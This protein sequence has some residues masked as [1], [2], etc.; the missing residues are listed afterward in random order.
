MVSVMLTPPLY[1]NVLQYGADPTGTTDSTTAIQDAL[2]AAGLVPG[3]AVFFPSGIYLVSASLTFPGNIAIIGTGD[4]IGGTIIRVKSGANLTTPVLASA[5]WYNNS[6]TCGNPIAIKDIKIDANSSTSGTSAHGIVSMNYWSIIERC[7]VTGVT[8]DGLRITANS[9]NGTHITNTCVEAKLI[10]IEARST[11]G[12]GIRVYDTGSPLNSYTDGFMESCIVNNAGTYGI[13]VDMAPGWYLSGNHVYGTGVDGINLAKCYATRVI[14]NYVDGFASG[15]STYVSG[16]HM[17]CIDGRGS[18]CSG[19]IVSFESGSATGPYQGFSIR[20]NGSATSICHVYGNH[21]NGGSQ[22]GSLGYVLQTQPGQ[23]PYPWIVYFRDN[24]AQNCASYSFV[25][26]YVTP[27]QQQNFGHILANGIAQ[28]VTA[29]AGSNAGT[30]PPSPVL[31]RANDL[32]G[33]I[34]FGTGTSPSAGAQVTVTYARSYPNNPTIQL[35][36]INSATAALNLYISTSST[37][38][39]TV[40]CVNAPAASQANT[41][42]GFY[43]KVEG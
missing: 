18:V 10:R 7:F 23:Q 30:S 39:F 43:Y 19:N 2:N 27:G 16:I 21:V 8:G 14:G 40:G 6:T 9:Q 32:N 37:G 1:I 22:S 11:G 35:T 41:V 5:D 36:P 26:S 13:L 34:T 38:S 42:Y 24:D 33:K 28:A 25:D 29:A 15:S 20:G 12:S 31:T 4:A 17:D 3:S